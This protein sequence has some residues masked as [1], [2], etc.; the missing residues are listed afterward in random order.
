MK[1]PIPE[2]YVNCIHRMGCCLVRHNE[3]CN[4]FLSKKIL[5][6]FSEKELEEFR[7]HKG[8]NLSLFESEAS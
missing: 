4:Y 7:T 2:P 6:R 5:E 8:Q 1:T 3:E